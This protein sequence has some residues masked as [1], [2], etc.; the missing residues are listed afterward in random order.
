IGDAVE[1]KRGIAHMGWRSSSASQAKS[2]QSGGLS[3]YKLTFLDDHDQS[4]EIDFP[5]DREGI[6]VFIR[7]QCD[8]VPVISGEATFDLHTEQGVFVDITEQMA[9]EFGLKVDRKEY[10]KL[11]GLFQEQSR[12]GQKKHVISAVSGELPKTDDV[13]KYD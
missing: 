6:R 3:A 7:N 10:Q 2:K 1:R 13:A 11:F 4:V 12:H 9:A 8:G 5:T